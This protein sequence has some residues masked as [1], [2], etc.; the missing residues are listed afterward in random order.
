[1]FITSDVDSY[2]RQDLHGMSKESILKLASLFP[3]GYNAHFPQLPKAYKAWMVL[4][5]ENHTEHELD[6]VPEIGFYIKDSKD[7]IPE[8]LTQL[9]FSDN[10]ST[11]SGVKGT[12]PKCKVG[13]TYY[14]ASRFQ[15][16]VV[17]GY[18]S[19]CECIANDV[20]NALNIPC[21]E[22]SLTYATIKLS[23]KVVTTWICQSKDFLGKRHRITLF[24]FLTLMGYTD[25]TPENV[26]KYIFE[27]FG[28]SILN[29][30]WEMSV[31]DFIIDNTDRHGSNIELILTNNGPKLAP[32]FDCGSSLISESSYFEQTLEPK[33]ADYANN[34]IGSQSLSKAIKMWPRNFQLPEFKWNSSCL[35]KYIDCF[36]QPEDLL[37]IDNIIR[38][39]WEW[40]YAI[41]NNS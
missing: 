16:F 36:N 25:L 41:R 9:P 19:V 40:L 33:E 35:L 18:E 27:C 29:N 34:C 30:L 28:L 4:Q 15:N 21:V 10:F 8:D 39:R 5:I 7:L 13:N 6:Y 38:D 23:N 20:C 32:I 14:K 12:F 26:F 11:S 3:T 37:V 2:I 17:S 24:D 1:M 31:V 22:Y